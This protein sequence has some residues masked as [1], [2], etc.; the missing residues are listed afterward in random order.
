VPVEMWNAGQAG[1]PIEGYGYAGL[2]EK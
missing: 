1:P 2:E